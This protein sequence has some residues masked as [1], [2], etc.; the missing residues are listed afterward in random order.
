MCVNCAMIFN[1]SHR[2]ILLQ[3]SQPLKWNM[4]D[5]DDHGCV[6]NIGNFHYIEK[7]PDLSEAKTMKTICSKNM[8]P[9]AILVCNSL[10]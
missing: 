8:T 1:R 9:L 2:P 5:H 7:W 4:N 10:Q 3:T 6:T